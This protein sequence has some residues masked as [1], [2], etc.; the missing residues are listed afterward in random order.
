MKHILVLANLVE[1]V[2]DEM[3]DDN[4]REL[5]AGIGEKLKYNTIIE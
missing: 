2:V 5:W 4:V 1:S 3:T